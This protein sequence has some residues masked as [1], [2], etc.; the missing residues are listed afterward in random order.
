MGTQVL[1]GASDLIPTPTYLKVISNTR[2]YVYI[3]H[4]V[5]STNQSLSASPVYTDILL[6]TAKGTCFNGE[7]GLKPFPLH[8]SRDI[9]DLYQQCG[10]H[11][12]FGFSVLSCTHRVDST[13]EL[14]EPKVV[15][16]CKFVVS[17]GNCFDILCHKAHYTH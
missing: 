14:Y 10:M 8:N 2:I 5:I 3:N 9:S 15:I 17:T 12:L 7:D 13:L 11:C 16:P 6:I 1:I 4:M